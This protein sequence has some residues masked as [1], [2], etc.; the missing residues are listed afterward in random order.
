MRRTARHLK[1]ALTTIL[2]GLGACSSLEVT[3][4]DVDFQ[5]IEEVTFDPSLEIDLNIMSRLPSGVYI[6][7][8]TVG[9]GL[10]VEAGAVGARADV[11]YQGWLTNGSLFDAGQFEF[12]VG[13][14]EVIPGFELGVVGMKVGGTRLIIIPP[15]LA[16]GAN[17]VGSI[18]GGSV[19]IFEVD[20]VG[21]QVLH[22]G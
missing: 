5:V 9:E 13:A 8:I 3:V 7:D 11:A 20:L 18:P 14:Q 15:E 1:A 22:L 12:T 17:F 19:L 10:E 21:L 2:V 6:L 4:P 16:Y